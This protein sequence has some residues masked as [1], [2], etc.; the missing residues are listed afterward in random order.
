MN[1]EDST[2]KRIAR[3]QKA[4]ALSS[5]I[6]IYEGPKDLAEKHDSYSP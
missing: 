5:A 4:D 1:S 3:K 2:E 6:G